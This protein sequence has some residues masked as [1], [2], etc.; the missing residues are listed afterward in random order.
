MKA[1][2]PIK[3]AFKLTIL[4]SVLVVVCLCVATEQ[5]TI[6]E[7]TED[8]DNWNFCQDRKH[9][10]DECK[11][12]CNTYGLITD[13]TVEAGSSCSCRE[14]FDME[15]CNSSNQDKSTCTACCE[16][17]HLKLMNYMDLAICMCSVE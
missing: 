1:I 7:E 9:G 12:C 17:N 6:E 5:R 4:A 14:K 10:D 15:I 13:K 16:K 2:K 8:L 11:S 3:M